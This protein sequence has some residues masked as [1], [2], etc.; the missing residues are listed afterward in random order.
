M[1]FSHISDYAQYITA[2]L[3]ID[4]SPCILFSIVS[5]VKSRCTFSVHS[6]SVTSNNRITLSYSLFY[7]SS[8]IFIARIRSNSSGFG[9]IIS[10]LLSAIASGVGIPPINLAN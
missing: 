7:F 10:S 8:A 6:F 1:Q 4:S 5:S 3:F 9:L 2:M